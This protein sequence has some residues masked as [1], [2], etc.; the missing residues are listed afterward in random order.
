[1]VIVNKKDYITEIN[2]GGTPFF[3]KKDDCVVFFSRRRNKQKFMIDYGL[4]RMNN[5]RFVK[6]YNANKIP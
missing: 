6:Q 5:T 4:S 3:L 2:K 1:M